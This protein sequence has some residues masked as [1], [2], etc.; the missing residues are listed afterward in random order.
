MK[1]EVTT[2]SRIGA[3]AEQADKDGPELRRSAV[4]VGDN[5]GTKGEE[6]LTDEYLRDSFERGAKR[7]PNG[8]KPH[9]RIVEFVRAF[10]CWCADKHYDRL[11]KDGKQPFETDDFDA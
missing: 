1:I 9:P 7:P 11:L 8:G 5:T 2:E 3:A 10:A 4:R 6:G